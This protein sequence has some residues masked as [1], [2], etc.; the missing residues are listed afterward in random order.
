MFLRFYQHYRFLSILPLTLLL[1][2]CLR[3]VPAQHSYDN[4]AADGFVGREGFEQFAAQQTVK[5][6]ELASKRQSAAMPGEE[7]AY[8]IGAGDALEFNVFD[9][10]EMNVTERARASGFLSLPIIGSVQATGLTLDKLQDDVTRR[11]SNY[12]YNPQVHIYI[13]EYAAHKVAVMGAVARPGSYTLKKDRYSLVDILA[14][15]GGRTVDAGDLV[16]LIPTREQSSSSSPE[17]V[18]LSGGTNG[19]VEILFDALVGTTSQ[20]PVNIALRPGDTV[21]VPEA[22]TVQV[23]GEVTHPGSYKIASRMS[24]LGAIASAGGLTYSADV[25]SVEVIR[26]LGTGQK[27]LA[28]INL[29]ELALSGGKDIRLRS[30][31]MVR[32]PSA[33]GRFLTRQV[34][35]VINKAVSFG[36][37]APVF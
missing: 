13:T 28:T 26:E 21:V 2:G 31:D 35:D 36:I 18:T 11:L 12:M 24:V 34:V 7:A 1:A 33:S 17:V 14:E 22:G 6:T 32:I 25:D 27:A 19:G 9:V 4:S 16:I 15:A 8:H 30:G 29:E 3:Y 20:M 10:P 5:L 23:D 37:S